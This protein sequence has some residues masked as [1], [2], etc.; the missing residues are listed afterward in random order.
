MFKTFISICKLHYIDYL[1][2]KTYMLKKKERKPQFL[3]LPVLPG[4][5]LYMRLL[6]A[7]VFHVPLIINYLLV[8]S[9][10]AIIYIFFY[11]L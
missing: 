7:V 10:Y 6:I 11:Y 1:D 9:S 4:K 8:G 5:P 2:C 3:K